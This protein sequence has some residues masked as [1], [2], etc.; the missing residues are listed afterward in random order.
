MNLLSNDLVWWITVIDL[1]ALSGLLLMVWRVRRE[2]EEGLA[3]M[4]ENMETRSNQI[5]EGLSAFKLEVAK[6]YASHT[7]LKELEN[8][9]V[10]HLL[11]I[12]A[13]LDA[14]ALKAEALRAE[15]S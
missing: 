10:S 12:E 9:L 1:P 7:D 6:N 14:T 2:A 4:R 5:R 15:K 11:R 13:K 3:L 8:R